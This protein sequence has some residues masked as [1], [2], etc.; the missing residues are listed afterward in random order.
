MLHLG[1]VRLPSFRRGE[2]IETWDSAAAI[3]KAQGLPSFRRGE[4]IETWTSWTRSTSRLVSPRFGG[5][6]GLKLPYVH[7]REKHYLS[8]LVSAGGAD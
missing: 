6:S 2:R 7:E 3:F 1:P 8:P 4:R 5:G